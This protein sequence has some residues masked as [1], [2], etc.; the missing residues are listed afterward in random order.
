MIRL[1]L[2]GRPPMRLALDGVIPEALAGLSAVEIAKRPLGTGN[3]QGQ[4]GDWFSV[5]LEEG[6]DQRLVVG[7]AS[8]RLDRVGAGM[9]SGEIVVEGDVG[10]DAGLAMTGGRL[11]IAGSAGHRAAAAMGGGELR[12][13]GNAGDQLGGALP[14]DS[15]GMREGRV[16]VAG[17]AGA[18]AGDRMRRGLIVIGGS[19]SAFCG[20]RMRAGT[21]MVGGALGP[22]PGIAM[23]RGTILAL[24]AAPHVPASF[25]DCGTHELTYARLLARVLAETGLAHLTSRLARLHRWAGDLASAGKGELLV[26]M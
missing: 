26:A 10:A 22:H 20:A 9:R 15:L 23:R 14:G 21:I 12:I 6:G 18:G 11:T 17:S 4:L 24:G 2:K 13:G 7:E 8:N 16:T 3:R 25:A 19:A 5:D 1:T